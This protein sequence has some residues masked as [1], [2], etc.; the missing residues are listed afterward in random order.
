MN[1]IGN[2]V[3]K[4]AS[5]FKHAFSSRDAMV[6]YLEAPQL[7]GDQNSQE[8]RRVSTSIST[9][10]PGPSKTSLMLLVTSSG[11]TVIWRVRHLRTVNGRSGHS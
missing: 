4:K 6:E 5:A 10:T 2:K 11:L 7:E 1:K 8:S 3:N 9:R